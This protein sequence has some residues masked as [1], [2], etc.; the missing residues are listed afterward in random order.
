LEIS[1]GGSRDEVEFIIRNPA[2]FVS[3]DSGESLSPDK[4]VIK[5]SVPKQ[6]PTGVDAA[7]LA[8]SAE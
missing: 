3:A 6:L 8:A 4:A 7:E 5:K 2:Q 1:T